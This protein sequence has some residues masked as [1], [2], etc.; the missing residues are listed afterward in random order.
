MKKVITGTA[1]TVVAD[2]KQANTVFIF[3][4]DLG[5]G[6]AKL[7]FSDSLGNFV[8]VEDGAVTVPSTL[9]LLHGQGNLPVIITDNVTDLVVQSYGG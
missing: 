3:S 8:D 5:A 9:S 1:N 7:A 4:G 6:S 2:H